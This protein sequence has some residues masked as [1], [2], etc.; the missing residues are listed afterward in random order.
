MGTGSDSQSADDAHRL[1]PFPG[2]ARVLKAARGM[3]TPEARFLF[4]VLVLRFVHGVH[5]ASLGVGRGCRRI[6]A[7][8]AKL[9]RSLLGRAPA[10]D[11]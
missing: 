7:S 6:A 10:K 5:G 8:I 4:P 1:L 9:P 3:G 11:L 2:A